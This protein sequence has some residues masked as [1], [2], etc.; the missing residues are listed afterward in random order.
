MGLQNGKGWLLRLCSWEPGWS[1][2]TA[3]GCICGHAPQNQ[4]AASSALSLGAL[5]CPLPSLA[6]AASDK[7]HD[8]PLILLQWP[9]LSS[10]PELHMPSDTPCLAQHFSGHQGRP[11]V[12]IF[13]FLSK[14]LTLGQQFAALFTMS[15]CEGQEWRRF[16]FQESCFF[17]MKSMYNPYTQSVFSTTDK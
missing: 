5:G 10:W 6:L 9:Q 12:C 11:K 2:L 3:G 16:A 13:F 14:L 1:R 7:P 17:P 4:K 8:A 15:Q